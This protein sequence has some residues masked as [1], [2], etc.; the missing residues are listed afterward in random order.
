MKKTVWDCNGNAD[1]L[2]LVNNKLY[3]HIGNTK[4]NGKAFN[5]RNV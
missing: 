1:T 5:E 3:R 4:W 2:E